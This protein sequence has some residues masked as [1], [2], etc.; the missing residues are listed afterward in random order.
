[1]ECRDI[2]GYEGIYKI[3]EYGDIYSIKTGKFRKA[4]IGTHGY[5]QIDLYKNGECKWFRVHRLVALTYIPNPYNL[6]VV[7]HLDNNKT[8]NHISNLIWGTVQTNTKQA[9][10]DGLITLPNL[11]TYILFNQTHSFTFNYLE[12]LS[13]VT[14]YSIG[15][16]LIYINNKQPLLKGNYKGYTIFRLQ[17][18]EP[19]TTI[20]F[21]PAAKK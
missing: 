1:M 18:I 17:D 21:K 3:S 2:P 19:S 11:R 4:R 13:I 9:Y 6:P 5:Y 10:D 12:D 7:M 20:L 8:N 14:G 16:L 15:Q